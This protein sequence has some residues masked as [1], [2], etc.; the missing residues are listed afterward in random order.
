MSELYEYAQ[1]RIEENDFG[2]QLKEWN[3]GFYIHFPSHEA[4]TS[5]KYAD[6][7]DSWAFGE[8][9]RTRSNHHNA[10]RSL[11]LPEVYVK[12]V[13]KYLLKLQNHDKVRALQ[14]QAIQIRKT[15]VYEAD[16]DE[17]DIDRLM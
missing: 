4:Y 12:M 17:L 10:L 5:E 3:E 13:K 15:K 7:S 14:Q 11:K 16:G 9:I 8:S 1:E 6:T 2:Q